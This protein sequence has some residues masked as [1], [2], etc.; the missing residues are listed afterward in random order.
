MAET[1]IGTYNMSFASDLGK[2]MG[3][4]ATFL[5]RNKGDLRQ[6]WNNAKD[7]LKHFIDKKKPLAVGLQEMNETEQGSGTGSDAINEIL[8][9]T[10]YKQYVKTIIVNEKTKPALSI[11]LDTARTG[12]IKGS[13]FLDNTTQDGRPLMMILTEKDEQKMLF[14]NIHGAQDPSLENREK[15]FILIC[16][17]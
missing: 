14:I 7:H 2:L 12:D 13:L 10:T 5:K 8:K 17:V 11:I 6:Y 3:S 16:I 1:F 15:S 4:E 9:G